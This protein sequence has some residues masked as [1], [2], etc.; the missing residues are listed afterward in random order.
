[1]SVQVRE[2]RPPPGGWTV[3]RCDGRLS[4]QQRPG[5]A[6]PMKAFGLHPEGSIEGVKQR[7]GGGSRIHRVTACQHRAKH[8]PV[9]DETLRTATLWRRCCHARLQKDTKA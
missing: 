5:P 7:T 8:L 3:S 6:N 2:A 1:M 4:S 9:V